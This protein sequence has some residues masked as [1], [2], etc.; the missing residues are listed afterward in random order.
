ML[1][2]A[3]RYALSLFEK[4]KEKNQLDIVLNELDNF[5]QLLSRNKELLELWN[6]LSLAYTEKERL[7]LDKIAFTDTTKN[8][9][10]L[11]L[12]KKR[13]KLLNK[14]FYY[15]KSLYNK[16]HNIIEVEIKSAFEID[17]Q[18]LTK[19]IN[20]LQEKIGLKIKV[21]SINIEK[22]IIGGIIMISD[23]LILD[24]SV[25]KD[26]EKLLKNFQDIV[27]NK[28]RGLKIL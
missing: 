17:N 21:K 3:S 18:D 15:Y 16:F 27:E 5:I 13:Q 9:L 1:S 6:S 23:N 11:I 26:L 19:L 24:L 12:Y 8:F 7:I 14:I 2:V 25:K 4:A 22:E 28:L 10:K 20:T